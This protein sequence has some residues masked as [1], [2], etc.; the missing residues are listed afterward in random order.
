MTIYLIGYM[1][2]GKTTLGTLLKEIANVTFT[3]LDQYIE[4]SEGKTI[5]EIFDQKGEDEFRNMERAAL[6]EVT[7]TI[8]GVIA[9]GG[10][11]PCFFDNMEY[12]KENGNVVYL[13][14]SR[15]ELFDR[16]KIYKASRPLLK[17]KTDDEIKEFIENSLPKREPLYNNA[18]IIIDADPLST[19]EGAVATAKKVLEIVSED[20]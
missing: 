16:L 7:E 17:D 18:S 3:D 2:S 14:C 15:K 5:N 8:G 11:T 10:G 19:E 1:C 13:N 9:T 12:M 20:K 4:E 6:K